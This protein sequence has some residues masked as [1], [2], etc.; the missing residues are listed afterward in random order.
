[1]EG[2]KFKKD[3]KFINEDFKT[4][5]NQSQNAANADS[6]PGNLLNG[7]GKPAANSGHNTA[8]HKSLQAKKRE[9]EEALNKMAALVLKD[10]VFMPVFLWVEGKLAEIEAEVD[11]IARAQKIVDDQKAKKR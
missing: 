2:T 10:K 8:C 3:I 4:N 1:M 6:K 11:T 9:I 5:H 7:T